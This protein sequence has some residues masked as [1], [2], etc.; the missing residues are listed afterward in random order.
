MKMLAG[1]A[2]VVALAGSALGANAPAPDGK[3]HQ[4]TLHDN[5]FW[6]DQ[7]PMRVFAGEM[8]PG[9]ILPEFWDDRIKKAKAMG[10]NTISVYLFWN[11]I[12]PTEGNFVFKDQ[13]DILGGLRSCARTMG[14][15]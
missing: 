2:L 4:F 12:E 10:L 11:Q 6:V 15:G 1:F 3:P 5:Q 13:T 9:R 7:T 14:C 8:H